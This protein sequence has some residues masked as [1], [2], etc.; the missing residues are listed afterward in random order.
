MDIMRPLRV[1]IDVTNGTATPA[2]P[3]PQTVHLNAA[4][5]QQQHQKE[6]PSQAAGPPLAPQPLGETSLLRA[7]L[8]PGGTADPS[9]TQPQRKKIPLSG[10]RSSALP[11]PEIPPSATAATSGT[12]PSAPLPPAPLCT[13][14]PHTASCARLLQTADIPP[15]TAR[16]VLCH[17]PW[18]TEDVLFCPNDALPAFVTGIPALYSGPEPWIAVHNHRPEPLQLHSG[19]NIGILEV[20]TLAETP[21]STSTTSSH[22]PNR[23]NHHSQ[24][25]SRRSSSNS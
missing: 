18:P 7:S 17:N 23:V 4:Q 16:L 20:V 8:S 15:E 11:P 10:A 12:L 24:S 13:A 21:A 25:A 19:Q 9:S 2:Q 1:H 5:S 14:N 6:L 3:D 22:P